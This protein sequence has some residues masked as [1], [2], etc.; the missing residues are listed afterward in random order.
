MTAK[1]RMLLFLYRTV[2]VSNAPHIKYYPKRRE[3]SRLLIY[4]KGFFSHSSVG[5]KPPKL[6]YFENRYIMEPRTGE[7]ETFTSSD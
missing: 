2:Y 7:I 3:I 4:K 6:I 1:S 5:L